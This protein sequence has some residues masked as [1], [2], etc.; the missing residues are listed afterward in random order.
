[1]H[2]TG[3]PINIGT[4]VLLGFVVGVAISGQTF[5]AFV[6]ENMRNLGALKAM[7]ASSSTICAMLILQSLAVGLIGYGLGMG[8]VSLMGNA[9][10]QLQKVP[11]LLLWQIPVATLLAVVLIC[12]FSALLG[13][14]RVARIEAAIV[15]RS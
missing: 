5:Y 3:I 7:G 15:F 4:L 1:V 2:N 14:W 9:L 11:F 8:V 10:L 13:I 6:H 12:V